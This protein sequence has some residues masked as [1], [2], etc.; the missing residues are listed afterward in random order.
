MKK[1]IEWLKG[2]LILRKFKKTVSKR[3][4]EKIREFIK[5][6]R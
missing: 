2:K 1:L 6:G 4:R 3:K 5:E